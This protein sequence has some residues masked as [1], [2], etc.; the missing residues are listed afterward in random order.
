VTA[1]LTALTTAADDRATGI[2]LKFAQDSKR[3]VEQRR[4]AVRAL[5]RTKGGAGSLLKLAQSKQLN[6]DLEQAAG[7]ALTVVTWKNLRDDAARLFP[8][9]PAKDRPLPPLT[10]LAKM[11]GD[12]KKG[13]TVFKG[14]G[15]CASCHIVNG[16]GKEVGPDLSEVGKKLGREAMLESI[17]YPSAGISHG[18]ET[19][20]VE[21]TTG[22]VET[23]LKISDTA[24]G[25]SLRGAD[26][27]LR[28]VKRDE[29]ARFQKSSQSLMPADLTK[30]MTA[31][32]LADVVEYMLTLRE[33][34]A[35]KG[36][37]K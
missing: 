26:G 22:G 1:T 12:A 14:A 4:L 37:K 3:D 34:R 10:E 17:L 15:T 27:I 21:T 30:T 31:Q 5:A 8:V 25:V 32:D 28:S 9:P 23:G 13:F 33:A 24:E 29:I 11:R 18:Y 7:A 2:L 36:E 16:D 19:Y 6:K 20:V 35:V